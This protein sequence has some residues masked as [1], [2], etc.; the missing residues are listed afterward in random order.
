LPLSFFLCNWISRSASPCPFASIFVVGD[1]L[2]W[3]GKGKHLDV[4]FSPI[5]LGYGSTWCVLRVWEEDAPGRFLGFYCFWL[6]V[7]GFNFF[8]APVG[9]WA[10]SGQLL[11]GWLWRRPEI[12][13]SFVYTV[14]FQKAVCFCD[15]KQTFSQLNSITAGALWLARKSVCLRIRKQIAVH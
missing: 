1:V 9:R 8:W 6:I 5:W 7:L 3:L 14:R 2:I 15:S 11:N 12:K 13:V 4:L 10:F